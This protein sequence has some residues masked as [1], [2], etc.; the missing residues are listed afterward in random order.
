MDCQPAEGARPKQSDAPILHPDP[1]QGK[2]N[3]AGWEPRAVRGLVDPKRRH[4]Q[5]HLPQHPRQ[6]QRPLVSPHRTAAQPSRQRGSWRTSTTWGDPRCVQASPPPPTNTYCMELLIIP[7]LQPFGLTNCWSSGSGICDEHEGDSK[8]ILL[9]DQA[10]RRTHARL[11]GLCGPQ[12]HLPLPGRTAA[13]VAG[14]KTILCTSPTAVMPPYPSRC[15][16]LIPVLGEPNVV[17]GVAARAGDRHRRTSAWRKIATNAMPKKK[18]PPPDLEMPD[19]EP[20]QAVGTTSADLLGPPPAGRDTTWGI[21]SRRRRLVCRTA[22]S[23]PWC[24]TEKSTA[25]PAT[26]SPRDAATGSTPGLGA[27]LWPERDHR[28]ACRATEELRVAA[29]IDRPP[30]PMR[31]QVDSVRPPAGSC[32]A[33]RCRWSRESKVMM[34][35]DAGLSTEILKGNRLL[36]AR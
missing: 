14:V 33:R 34:A 18:K 28:A 24:S 9:G 16:A 35:R 4:R 11:C 2:R 21:R 29:E 22:S 25:E 26:P 19:A 5:F 36:E 32:G 31:N 6:R 17:A 27:G 12:G 23:I 13:K 30:P 7:A 3:P 10:G 15:E 8:G 20:G 1:R